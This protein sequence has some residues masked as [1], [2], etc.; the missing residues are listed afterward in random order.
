VRGCLKWQNA[1]AVNDAEAHAGLIGE[2]GY[3]SVPIPAD[4]P[5]E[6]MLPVRGGTE[7]FAAWSDEPIKKHTRV[8]VVEDR[9]ARSVTVTPLQ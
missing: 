9:S 1:Y 3:V 5:G 6:V 2:V 7:A 8:V 4:G